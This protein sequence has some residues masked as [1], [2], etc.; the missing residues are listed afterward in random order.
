MRGLFLIVERERRLLIE[1]PRQTANHGID[2]PRCRRVRLKPVPAADKAEWECRL[3]VPE[4]EWF[5]GR[6]RCHESSCAVDFDP[7]RCNGVCSGL[8]GILARIPLESSGKARIAHAGEH[9][10]SGSWQPNANRTD[11]S[12]AASNEAARDRANV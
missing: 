1:I 12:G 3:V 5:D 4:L 9:P 6:E 11:L 2:V 7:R 10:R 8:S